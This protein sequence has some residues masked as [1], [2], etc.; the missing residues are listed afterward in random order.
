MHR[1]FKFMAAGALLQC[2]LLAPA[3]SMSATGI[4]TAA[5]T[6]AVRIQFAP[7]L[8]EPIRYRRSKQVAKTSG[9]VS[10]WTLVEYQFSTRDG[11][12]RLQVRPLDIG[13]D[14]A[15]ATMQSAFRRIMFQLERP[16]VLLL[17]EDGSI[18]GMED[19]ESYW[20]EVMRLSEQLI[21][22]AENPSTPAD[23]AILALCYGPGSQCPTRNTPGLV[24]GSAPCRSS[25]SV[26]MS[27][28]SES[29]SLGTS[30]RQVCSACRSDKASKFWGSGFTTAHIFIAVRS[31]VPREELVRGIERHCRASSRSRARVTTTKPSASK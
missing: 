27:L 1:I 15:N 22:Q 7:P 13:L 31:S 25:S 9:T 30:N 26:P 6:E 17:D 14:G 4:Q 28:R 19:E 8:D 18:L 12:Y 24:D 3:M 29:R 20:A 11:G 2:T 10:I 21:R 23:E 16:Y 5:P